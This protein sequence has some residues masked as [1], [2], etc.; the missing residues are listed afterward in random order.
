M[1][2]ILDDVLASAAL[3]PAVPER[4][5]YADF[6]NP[7]RKARAPFELAITPVDDEKHLLGRIGHVR[8]GDTQI[9]Q[10]SPYGGG[11]LVEDLPERLA[12]NGLVRVAEAGGAHG[13]LGYGGR[14]PIVL[15]HCRRTR[16]G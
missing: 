10:R 15:S 3:I 8:L 7:C 14:C 16:G 13:W 11:V 4:N 5:T 6:P 1:R 12:D 9:A 2:R